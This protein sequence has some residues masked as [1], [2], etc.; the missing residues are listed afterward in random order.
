LIKKKQAD[1]LVSNGRVLF[2]LVQ[3]AHL[4]LVSDK[5]VLVS[6]FVQV[7]SVT[8]DDAHFLM[9]ER[10]G[11]VVERVLQPQSVALQVVVVGQEEQIL[12]VQLAGR[13]QGRSPVRSDAFVSGRNCRT[14]L[15]QHDG[16]SGRPALE[17]SSAVEQMISFISLKG[18]DLFFLPDR[19]HSGGALELFLVPKWVVPIQVVKND[20]HRGNEVQ[21]FVHPVPF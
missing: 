7:V 8:P 3:K 11:Q 17:S 2:Q 13:A 21:V 15:N 19:L 1:I 4:E 14:V 10:L 12:G 18:L 20:D 6:G 5:E 16:H 9:V